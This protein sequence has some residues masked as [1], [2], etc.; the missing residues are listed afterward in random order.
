M[1]CRQASRHFWIF[2]WV[3]A[4]VRLISSTIRLRCL[5]APL[6]SSCFAS[7]L[8]KARSG[9]EKFRM[10]SFTLLMRKLIRRRFERYLNGG[11]QMLPCLVLLPQSN[12]PVVSPSSSVASSL[13]KPSFTG[14]SATAFTVTSICN[15]CATEVSGLS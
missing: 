9:L 2:F 3:S 10:Y 4:S 15:V 13:S 8:N 12:P 5:P 1:A 11:Y 6:L 14:T 7:A